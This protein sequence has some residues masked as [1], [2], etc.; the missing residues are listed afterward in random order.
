MMHVC[1]GIRYFSLKPHTTSSADEL[2]ISTTRQDTH[3]AK[4]SH[5]YGK[6]INGITLKRGEILH[7]RLLSGANNQTQSAWSGYSASFSHC[8]I[9]EFVM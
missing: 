6:K 1:I 5:D 4:S 3:L 9:R 8:N 7:M 2:Q